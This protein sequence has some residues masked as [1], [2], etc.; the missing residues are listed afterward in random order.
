MLIV[1][2]NLREKRD[3]ILKQYGLFGD[4]RFVI[5]EELGSHR[6]KIGVIGLYTKRHPN[7]STRAG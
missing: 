4:L 1:R 5:G 2:L 7:Q 3:D 6:F